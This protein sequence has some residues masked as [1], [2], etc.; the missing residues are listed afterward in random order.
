MKKYFILLLLTSVLLTACA[1]SKDNEPMAGKGG[2]TVETTEET[3]KESTQPAT[4]DTAESTTEQTTESTQDAT[5]ETTES[6]LESTDE[7][8]VIAPLPTTIDLTQLEDCTLSISLKEDGAY[9]DDT[10]VMRMDVTVYAYDLYDMADIAALKEG[11]TLVF[12]GED[13]II[14]SIERTDDGAVILNGGLD[15]GGY[16]LRH[17]DDGVFY[18]I[19]YSDAKYYYELGETTLRVS[20]D[21]LFIDSSDLD[22]G[23]ITYYPGDFLLEEPPFYFHF[24]PGDTT[25]VIQDGGIIEMHRIYMP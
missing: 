8:M 14:T 16:E 4:V 25:I 6:T 7:P 10:G 13:L 11:D 2:S 20:G 18:E 15:V 23:E 17:D 21:F 5:E 3:A 22:A 12:R 1:V 24:V 9:V 19:G